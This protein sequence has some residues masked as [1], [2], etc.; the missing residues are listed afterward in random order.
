[1]P[2]AYHPV[3]INIALPKEPL[4]SELLADFVANL[5]AIKPVDGEDI[6]KDLPEPADGVVRRAGNPR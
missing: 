6:R 5:D 1:M 3:Q 2:A 4:D